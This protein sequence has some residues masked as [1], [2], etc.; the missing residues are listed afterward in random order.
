MF[1]EYYTVNGN[2]IYDISDHLP[3]FVLIDNANIQNKSK[4]VFKRDYSNCDRNAL[5]EDFKMIDWTYH[6]DSRI[7]A[8]EM[9]DTFYAITN[10]IINK[11]IPLEKLSR[12]AVKQ[13]TKPWITPLIQTSNNIKNKY[14]KKI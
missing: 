7:T 8:D 6:F 1:E 4:R 10:E 5:I 2:I 13:T 14:Y 11:L 9:Y 3:N 12:K